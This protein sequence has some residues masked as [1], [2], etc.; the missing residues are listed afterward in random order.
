MLSRL[1]AV[2]CSHPQYLQPAWPGPPPLLWQIHCS[3]VDL[4]NSIRLD[5]LHSAMK[6]SCAALQSAFLQVSG[7]KLCFAYC[8]G[9]DPGRLV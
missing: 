5:M 4:G 1:I 8:M 3:F 6:A 9:G 7:C 2:C